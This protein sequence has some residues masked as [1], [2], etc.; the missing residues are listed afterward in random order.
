MLA[1]L[2]FVAIAG[3]LAYVTVRFEHLQVEVTESQEVQGQ[4]N[5]L[6]F[7]VQDAESNVRGYLLTGTQS[8]VD[9][10]H[11]ALAEVG[12]A[13]KDL[14]A[15]AANRPEQRE[16]LDALRP[17]IETR[18]KVLEESVANY[19]A[20]GVLPPTQFPPG[21]G[22]AM[23]AEARAI[24]TEMMGR[25]NYTLRPNQ[26]EVKRLAAT[27][28]ILA[29][30]LLFLLFVISLFGIAR[31]GLRQRE[32][33][34][35]NAKLSA[36]ISE[37]IEAEIR[38]KESDENFSRFV[39]GVSDYAIYRLDPRGFITTWNAGAT[40]IKGYTTQEIIGRHFSCFYTPEDQAAGTPARVLE[41]AEREG[42]YEAE[43]TVRVRKDGTTFHANVVVDRL[44]DHA[45]RLIGYAKITRD[46]SERV[47]QQTTLA[48]TQ[49]ALGQSQ[50]ME[51]IGHLTG[52]IA[53][54]F[55]NMLAV[56]IGALNMI[57][58]RIGRGDYN[59]EPLVQAAVEGAMRGAS[60]TQRLLAFARKQ[61]LEPRPLDPNKLISG[62]SELIRR[63][64]G[65]TIQT[66]V[67]TEGG[68]WRIFA[69]AH[70]LET[71]II[72]L[73]VNARDAMG[74]DGKLT[75]ETA[76]ASLSE[77]Y[78]RENQI[79][80]GQYVA[81]CVTDTGHGMSPDV[82][83]K[84]FDP[85]YTTKKT[86]TGLGLSQV[87]GF[88]KQSGGHVKIY[89]EEGVGTTVKIYLPRYFGNKE[90]APPPPEVAPP[91][92]QA[93]ETILVVEDEDAV[94]KLTTQSLAD[95]GY[96]VIE[97]DGGEQ[98]LKLLESN[99]SIALLFTDVVMPHMNGRQLA[100]E[101]AKLRPDLKVLYTTGYTRNA[102]VH[103]GVLDPDVK[104]LPKPFTLDALAR[105]IRR[106]IDGP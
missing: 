51:A 64:L 71:A 44:N 11:A 83:A 97:A 27:P 87:Y 74:Q 84:V 1:S 32:L 30:V 25:E 39:E 85:F 18:L 57:Q 106:A 37:R 3:T 102:V 38:K 70:Q 23:M 73:V 46:V 2:V 24:I 34:A 77:A 75:I 40:R 59:V 99:P 53:H 48:A 43:G 78:A 58:R 63:A 67:V 94:R 9:N 35:A 79:T 12:P 19:G 61:V 80:S 7:S 47:A 89:S 29:Y 4:L 36:E 16:S 22:P 91:T 76:N 5:R 42:H 13:L 33:A 56:I 82:V 28:Q 66:E 104:L 72:N 15:Y 52:G 81:I 65:E 96:T 55:N 20:V 90:E 95:L 31:S 62:M 105:A 100:V 93:S 54:D 86:G 103:N 49:A 8:Y 92:A 69:D 26:I 45:G 6:L 68:I 17:V 50:K 14:E 60:L 88:V 10:Y 41:T 101:A 21:T 98:A